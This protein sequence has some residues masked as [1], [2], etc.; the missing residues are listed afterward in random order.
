MVNDS[1]RFVQGLAYK[2]AP[3]LAPGNI[4]EGRCFVQAL[5]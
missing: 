5:G 3:T 1:P 2:Q 4:K